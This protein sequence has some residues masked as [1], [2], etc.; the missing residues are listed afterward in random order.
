MES[1]AI[2]QVAYQFHIPFLIVR[3]ISDR[4]DHQAAVSF[5]TFIQE[6]GVK[7]AQTT[8]AF[9]EQVKEKSK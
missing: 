7:S 1:T 2:G 9:V 4:A 6:V 3:A 5:E 8:L